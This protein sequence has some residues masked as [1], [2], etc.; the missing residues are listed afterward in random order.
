MDPRGD[1][2]VGD[3]HN[4]AFS[5]P[6]FG[7]RGYNEDE[8]DAVLE[9]V[10][11]RLADPVNVHKPRAIDIAKVVFSKPPIGK[12]GYAED[13]VD[14]FMAAVIRHLERT[15]GAVV[16]RPEPPPVAYEAP[17]PVA[18]QAYEAPPLDAPTTKKWWQLW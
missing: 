7:Q 12:R 3:V 10:E 5:K 14:A 6:P 9:V 16:G 2:T 8:V 4:V 18:S 11:R 15:D 13:E 1:L 17:P